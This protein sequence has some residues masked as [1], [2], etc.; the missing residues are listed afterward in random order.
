MD[1]LG[2]QSVVFDSNDTPMLHDFSKSS[3]NDQEQ[4]LVKDIRRIWGSRFKLIPTSD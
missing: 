2:L 3:T 4:R 1:K